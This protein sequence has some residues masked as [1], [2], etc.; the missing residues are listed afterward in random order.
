MTIR[1]NR[2][3]RRRNSVPLKLDREVSPAAAAI[4]QLQSLEGHLADWHRVWKAFYGNAEPDVRL[5]RVTLSP[6]WLLPE[7]WTIVEINLLKGSKESASHVAT[8]QLYPLSLSLCSFVDQAP[9]SFWEGYCSC[10]TDYS[11]H[12][13]EWCT[14]MII[15]GNSCLS[16]LELTGIWKAFYEMATDKEETPQNSDNDRQSNRPA[17]GILSH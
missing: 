10:R 9:Y 4:Q 2:G 17:P 15:P 13:Q 8:L 1:P 7:M 14:T 12:R 5:R 6:P 16:D 11:W 3:P